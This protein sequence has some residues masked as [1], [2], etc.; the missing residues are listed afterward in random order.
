MAR[1]FPSTSWLADPPRAASRDGTTHQPRLPRMLRI[2][3]AF[4]APRSR[5]VDNDVANRK[6]VMALRDSQ[7]RY[8]LAQI[9]HTENSAT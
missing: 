6:T 8:A 3:T 7:G 1:G 5:S 4:E 2:I 9:L